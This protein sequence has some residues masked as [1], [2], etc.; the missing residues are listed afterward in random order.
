[1][2]TNAEHD[3]VRMRVCEVRGS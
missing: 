2:D 1:M 3:T